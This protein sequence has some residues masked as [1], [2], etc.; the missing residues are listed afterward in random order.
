VRSWQFR[1]G[2][3]RLWCSAKVRSSFFCCLFE[4]QARDLRQKVEAVVW[5]WKLQTWRVGVEL[6]GEDGTGRL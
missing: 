2:D 1:I 6:E 3:W 5:N 4:S